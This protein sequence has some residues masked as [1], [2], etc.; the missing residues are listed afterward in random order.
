MNKS[1]SFAIEQ[2]HLPVTNIVAGLKRKDYFVG[3]S[4]LN[5][6]IDTTHPVMSGMLENAKIF[7]DRSLVFTTDE[8]FE[9]SILTIYQEEGSSLTSGYMLG[10]K[11]L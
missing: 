11:Y 5:V 4:I 6:K 2:L 9:G 8:G 3:T 10:E 1:S 7:V